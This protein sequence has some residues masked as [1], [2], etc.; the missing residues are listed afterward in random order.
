M[1]FIDGHERSD[2]VE[3]Y[4]IF[5]NR[6]KKLKPYVVGFEKNDFIKFNTYS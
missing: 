2:V 6:I 5:E 1:T 3:N 4:N